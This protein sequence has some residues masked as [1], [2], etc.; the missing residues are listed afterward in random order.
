V[1]IPKHVVVQNVTGNDTSALLQ[2][3]TGNDTSA[4][5][6]ASES[7]ATEVEIVRTVAYR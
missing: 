6:N 3:V 5:L 4:L 2:N 7:I 1:Y